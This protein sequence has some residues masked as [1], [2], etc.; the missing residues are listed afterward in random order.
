MQKSLREIT[1]EEAQRVCKV[2]KGCENCPLKFATTTY[3]G[4]KDN[5][6]V[7][8]SYSFCLI[9]L[10][11][12]LENVQISVPDMVVEKKEEINEGQDGTK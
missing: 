8:N 10:V 3:L 1:P 12:M 4:I 6:L 2:Q 9:N 5:Q 7:N 11:E